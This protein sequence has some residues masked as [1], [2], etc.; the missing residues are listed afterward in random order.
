MALLP[1]SP[2]LPQPLHPIPRTRPRLTRGLIPGE[3]LG[4]Q[5]VIEGSRIGPGMRGRDEPLLRQIVER[6]LRLLSRVPQLLQALGDLLQDRGSSIVAGTLYSLL[7]ASFFIV[8]RRILPERVFGRRETT[9]TSLKAATG[10]IR[11]RTRATSSWR[12]VSGSR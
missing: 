8:P 3:G 12:M 11:S 6:G 9:A 5:R 2:D 1:W 7:S 10:P 4:D